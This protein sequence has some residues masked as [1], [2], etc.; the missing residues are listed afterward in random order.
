M[1][2]VSAG[3]QEDSI[4]IYIRLNA[5]FLFV[6]L[7]FAL[8]LGVA[9]SERASRASAASRRVSEPTRHVNAPSAQRNSENYN[10]TSRRCAPARTVCVN[11]VFVFVKVGACVVTNKRAASN[12][13]SKP[14]AYNR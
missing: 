10:S 3:E 2:K 6:S 13:F 8:C 12:P 1:N 7:P 5:L 11:D 14:I 9:L 4:F